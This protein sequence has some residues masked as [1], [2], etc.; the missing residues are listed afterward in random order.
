[1]ISPN[2][3][4]EKY[5]EM[6]ENS[7][8]YVFLVSNESFNIVSFRIDFRGSKLVDL[9]DSDELIQDTVIGP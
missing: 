2:V 4:I 1:M 3:Y 9:L 6:E 5:M 7:Q 8:V